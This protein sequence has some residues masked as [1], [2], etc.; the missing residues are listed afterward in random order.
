MNI[1]GKANICVHYASALIND[2]W[3]GL[4]DKEEKALKVWIKRNPGYYTMK[5]LD[6]EAKFSRDDIV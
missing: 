2:D 1:Q 4:D 3:S 5:D 6:Q